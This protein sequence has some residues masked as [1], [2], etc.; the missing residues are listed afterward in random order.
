MSTTKLNKLEANNEIKSNYLFANEVLAKLCSSKKEGRINL[1]SYNSDKNLVAIPIY[2]SLDTINYFIYSADK[3]SLMMT[4]KTKELHSIN[5]TPVFRIIPK[6]QEKNCFELLFKYKQNIENE[7]RLANIPIT[8]CASN[9]DEKFD[10]LREIVDSKQCQLNKR[11]FQSLGIDRTKV[12]KN[13]NVVQNLVKEHQKGIIDMN[14]PNN[15]NKKINNSDLE[16]LRKLKQKNKRRKKGD[17]SDDDENERNSKRLLDYLKNLKYLNRNIFNP[18]DPNY[19]NFLNKLKKNSLSSRKLF[20]IKNLIS[21][22][23]AIF[24]RF[25]FDE[26]SAANKNKETDLDNDKNKNK[27]KNTINDID[28][29]NFMKFL[30]NIAKRS[31]KDMEKNLNDMIDEEK[32]RKLRENLKLLD[33]LNKI[34]QTKKGN[35]KMCLLTNS[36]GS[37]YSNYLEKKKTLC[38]IIHG[39]DNANR[40]KDCMGNDKEFCKGCCGKFAKK[41]KLESCLRDCKDYLRRAK[42]ESDF[43]N[44][45]GKPNRE[46]LDENDKM[47]KKKNDDII[48][49]L[50]KKINE[51]DKNKIKGK[52][53]PR[54]NRGLDELNKLIDESN[55]KKR[56]KAKKTPKRRKNNITDNLLNLF[57]AN[58]ELKKQRE[59][60]NKKRNSGLKKNNLIDDLLNRNKPKKRTK[61]KRKPFDTVSGILKLL[62]EEEDENERAK[63]KA[64]ARAKAKS[65]SKGKKKKDNLISDLLSDYEKSERD[66]IERQRKLDEDLSKKRINK[67]IDDLE[68]NKSNKG[69]K[70]KS[71]KSNLFLIFFYLNF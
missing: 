66:R 58:R 1:I 25:H 51:D 20:M 5:K 21:L 3:K 48:S 35:F 33:S 7:E 26:L 12:Y 23:I 42:A 64:R 10:Y 68:N 59:E 70:K 14:D 55:E 36:P 43:L 49:N 39:F 61:P 9:A 63:A 67:I 46:E 40:F 28:S 60:R 37:K 50:F 29:K 8:L 62:K 19:I 38:M 56:R 17:G 11:D 16:Y 2:I 65:D 41:E 47:R 13:I 34:E 6:N 30:L 52:K 18:N 27:N 69:K 71:T 54:R 53:K 4:F 15:F 32:E 44:S 57:N 22:R 45:I 31:I 24:T